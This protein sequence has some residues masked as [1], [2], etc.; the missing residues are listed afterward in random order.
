MTTLE[1]LE[2]L[3]Y[4]GFKETDRQL[5]ETDRQLKETDQQVKRTSLEV[6]KLSR[7][8]RGVTNSIGLF[9]ESSVRPAIIRL[10]RERGII[11]NHVASRSEKRINGD[12]MEIDVLGSGPE[13]VVLVEVKFKL[14]VEDVKT[15]LTDLQRFHDFFP[16]YR[17]LALYGAVA[18]MS[19]VAGTERHAYQKGLF[20]L[21]QSGDNVR[22]LND[23]KF[24][25]QIFP[26][27][28]KRVRKA[29]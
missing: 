13:A 10:F 1:K 5:K 22:I 21:A 17:N 27:A 19:I 6:A 25:P 4:H 9:A 29:K 11:L 15:T 23:D 20:V 3:V 28:A 8:V 24:R 7:E 18:G 26:L 12:A 2:D 14:D 16:E